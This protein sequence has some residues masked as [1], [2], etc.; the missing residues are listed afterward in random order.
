MAKGT[1][2]IRDDDFD[3]TPM[4][5]WLLALAIGLAAWVAVIMVISALLTP[6][7]A[8]DPAATYARLHDGR[9]LIM[10]PA[11]MRAKIERQIDRGTA[12]AVMEVSRSVLRQRCTGYHPAWTGCTVIMGRTPVMVYVVAGLD[13]H[14]RRIVAVH[15]LAH[16]LYGWQHP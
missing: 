11:A 16:Y 9:T 12:P 4:L 6:A 1:I 10:P 15:E 5:H 7:Q 3:P 13:A 8:A 2:A 14:D